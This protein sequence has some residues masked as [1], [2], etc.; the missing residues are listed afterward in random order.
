MGLRRGPQPPFFPE[1]TQRPTKNCLFKGHT[2][3]KWE[4]QIQ[5]FQLQGWGR[6][7]SLGQSDKDMTRVQF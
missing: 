2:A 3:S 6:A 4:T 7:P 1:A 5:G